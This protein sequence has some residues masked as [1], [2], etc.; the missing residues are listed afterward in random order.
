MARFTASIDDKLKARLDTYAEEQ[1]F[2]RSEALEVMIRAFFEEKTGAPQLSPVSPLETPPSVPSATQ[3]GSG[4]L[5]E[6]EKQMEQLQAQMRVKTPRN[7]RLEL[8][9]LQER[10]KQV[11]NFATAQ[12]DYLSQLHD[13]V[14][15]NAQAG[16]ASKNFGAPDYYEPSEVPPAP[17]WADSSTE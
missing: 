9:E 4:R 3:P 13:V 1:G 7:V 11:Q 6:L 15:T 10:L 12:H 14:V 5:D 2:N 16:M 8:L 17:E